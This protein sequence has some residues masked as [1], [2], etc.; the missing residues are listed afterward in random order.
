VFPNDVLVECALHLA[1]L[2]DAYATV[3]FPT[4]PMI[5][6]A[7]PDEAHESVPSDE[8]SSHWNLIVIAFFE[9]ASGALVTLTTNSVG[10]SS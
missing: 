1:V 8:P 6:R 2:V 7:V 4:R 5:C 10:L 9:K 3:Q